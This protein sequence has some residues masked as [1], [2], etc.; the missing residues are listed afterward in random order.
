MT[1]TPT[2]APGDAADTPV[3]ADPPSDAAAHSGGS[4]AV[5]SPT[6]DPSA[7]DPSAAD[8]S[9]VDSPAADPAAADPA[10]A[11]PSAADPATAD[12]PAVDPPAVDS[13]SGAG[14]VSQVAPASGPAVAVEVID[15]PEPRVLPADFRAGFVAVVGRP[16]VGKS[17]L[18]NQLVGERVAI[19]TPKPQTTRDRIRGI[20]TFDD[21]QLVLVD[22]PGIH[23]PQNLLNRYMVEL[24]VGTVGDA[25]LVYLLIDAPHMASKP[26]QVLEKN[27][28]IFAALAKVGTPAFLVLNKID[29]VKDKAQLLPMIEALS[30]Q[31]PF[32]E[33]VP[34]SALR[35]AG[36]ERL[37]ALTRAILPPGPM[38]FPEDSLTDLTAGEVVREQLFLQLRQELPYQVALSVD[39]WEERGPGLVAIYATIHVARD[40]HKGMVIGRQGQRLRSVGQ[41]ARVAL[42]EMLEVRVF[43]DLNVR[44]ESKWIDDPRKLKKL[45]YDES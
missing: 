21:W 12:P 42:E 43:L 3:T 17:T 2:P 24:A 28:P 44:V 6:E 18:T 13:P 29:R 14:S 8:P 22:T 5:D 33:V 23:E 25:D 11:D 34:I 16:N 38:L 37:L 41:A 9:A 31:H 19:T 1:E 45:G 27:A 7:A 32:V 40:G 35:G 10:A 4:P 30:A 36:T 26:D 39:S 20:R 15:P